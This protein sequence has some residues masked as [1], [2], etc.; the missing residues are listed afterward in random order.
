M[1]AMLTGYLV[2]Y[3]MAAGGLWTIYGLTCA[4]SLAFRLSV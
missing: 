3:L 2:L 1:K 4:A